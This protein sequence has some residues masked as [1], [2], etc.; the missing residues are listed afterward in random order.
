M[1]SCR[2]ILLILS[3]AFVAACGNTPTRTT[4]L[5]RTEGRW[6]VD[7]EGRVVILRGINV[8]ERSKYPPFFPGTGYGDSYTEANTS[9]VTALI[10]SWGMNAVRFLIIWEA[11]EPEPDAF[12][13]KYLMH[14]EDWVNAFADEGIYVILD[15]HQD[16]YSRYFGGDGAPFWAVDMSIPYTFTAPWFVNYLSPAVV[17]NW[18]MFWKSEDLQA[19]YARAWQYVAERFRGHPWVI[20]YEIMNEPFYGSYSPITPEFEQ[21]ALLPFYQ[22]VI[23]AIREVDK[24]HIILIEPCIVKGGGLRSFLTNP[25]DKNIVYAPHYYDPTVLWTNPYD[26]NASRTKAAFYTIEEEADRMNVPWVLGEWGIILTTSGAEQYIR[27]HLQLLDEFMAGWFYWNFN[28][29]DDWMSPVLSDGT[30]RCTNGFCLADLLTRPQPTHV[31]GYPLSLT[32]NENTRTF[33]LCF[34]EKA[35]LSTTETLLRIPPSI[36]PRGYTVIISD[37]EWKR[38]DDTLVFNHSPAGANAKHCITVAPSDT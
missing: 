10:R 26:G 31:A 38:V 37:G 16:I 5:L 29:D 32:Y 36:Y 12:N 14:V 6:I 19:H 3:W 24:D 1:R 13:D 9:S 23:K 35:T 34:R 22:R 18:D 33:S 21:E 2:A 27:H 28:L 17:A 11:I 7:S 20:G 25:R 8:S 4:E 30:K 15:M